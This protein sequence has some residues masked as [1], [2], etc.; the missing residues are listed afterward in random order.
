MAVNPT[1]WKTI[2][3]A[4]ASMLPLALAACGAQSQAGVATLN[5]GEED[6]QR[7]SSQDAE[8]EL[9]KWAE[10]MREKGID[11]PDPSVDGDGNMIIARRAER[12]AEGGGEAQPGMRRLDDDFGKAIEECGDPP[13]ATGS[14]PSEKERAEL[15][16]SALKLAECMRQH[17]IS[18]FPDPDFSDSGPG[19][20]AKSGV[21]VEGPFGEVDMSD[22]D[23]QAAFEACRDELPQRP[24]V[25]RGPA[26]SDA[27]R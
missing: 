5:R 14:G 6:P 11:I 16:E 19:A 10:C 15:Q 7:A 8:R 20:G 18:D 21:R 13:R 17:G 3:L 12:P 4:L 27:D 24:F 1:S 2:K 23:V 25:M 9:L 26:A 22:P